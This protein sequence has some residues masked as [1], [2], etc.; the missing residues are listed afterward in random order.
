MKDS[1]LECRIFILLHVPDAGPVDE[2]STMRR[3]F[4]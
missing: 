1:T 4:P 3:R 2:V